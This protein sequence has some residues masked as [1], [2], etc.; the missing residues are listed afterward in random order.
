M[1]VPIPGLGVLRNAD[2][3]NLRFELDRD[4][5]GVSFGPQDVLPSGQ[6]AA[7]AVWVAVL[8]E[9]VPL[10]EKQLDALAQFISEGL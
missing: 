10:D 1:L 4:P 5:D 6:K 9:E 8:R 3:H 7:L 2:G